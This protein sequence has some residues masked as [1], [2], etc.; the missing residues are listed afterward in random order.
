MNDTPLHVTDFDALTGSIK[1]IHR[2]LS[3]QASRAANISLTVRNWLIGCYIAEFELHG[4]DRAHYGDKLLDRLAESLTHAGVKT[5]DKRRLYHYLRFY[6]AYPE[7]VRSLPAQ[8][9]RLLPSTVS[10]PVPQKVRSATAQLEISLIESLSYTHIEQ[11]VMDN[12]LFVSRY[13][14]E[15]PGKQIL[16]KQIEAERRRLED[17]P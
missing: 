11:L 7:I 16:Q 15:L 17:K 5:C 2:E 6:H 8:S 10:Q 13:Q 4:S 14:L 1:A 3:A 12:D 9:Q